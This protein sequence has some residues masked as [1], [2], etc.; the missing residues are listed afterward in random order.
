MA[1]YNTTK[2]YF[3]K[4]PV[5]FTERDEI[6]YLKSLSN[7]RTVILIYLELIAKTIN[8]TGI[9]AK[10]LGDEKIPYTIKEL[11]RIINEEESDIEESLELL[12]KLNLVY[13]LK[14]ETYFIPE[15]LSMTNQSVSANKK[16]KQ[17]QGKNFPPEEEI[18]KELENKKIEKEKKKS[19]KK[20]ENKNQDLIVYDDLT[21]EIKETKTKDNIPYKEI[22]EYLN[23]SVGSNYRYTTSKT[24]SLIKARY[25]E[26]FT[27]DDFINVIEKKKSEWLNTE[28]EKYLRPE[29]LFGTKFEGYLNQNE[30]KT[31][32]TVMDTLEAI[33][34]GTIRIK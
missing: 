30:I 8:K 15:A 29:T 26:G 24:Q 22:I 13:K 1:V 3:Y 28:Y 6:T 16:E 27:F 19:D 20:K 14:D 2:L 18:E 7:G 21:G 12:R 9:L 34:N 23:H 33:Y 10:V 25:N 11:S 17:K 4:M 32:D 31:A 5:T